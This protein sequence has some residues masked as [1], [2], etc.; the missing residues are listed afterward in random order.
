MANTHITYQLALS[1]IT[2][3]HNEAAAA[4]LTNEVPPGHRGGL[5]QRLVRS[6]PSGAGEP[7]TTYRRPA[8]RLADARRRATRQH[9]D[10]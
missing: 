3:F 8:P 9:L 4:R 2:E 1:R 10:A 5:W 7:A 6:L